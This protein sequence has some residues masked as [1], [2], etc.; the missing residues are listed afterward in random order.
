MTTGLI[1]STQVQDIEVRLIKPDPTQPRQVFDEG[2]LQNLAESLKAHGLKYPLRVRPSDEVG[3]EQTFFVVGG[4]RR[5]RAAC[6]AEIESLTCI[7]ND[8]PF[9]PDELL[10]EQLIDDLHSVGLS[11]LE[12]ARSYKRLMDLKRCS[13]NDL[14]QQLRVKRTSVTRPLSLLAL[15]EPL[16]KKLEAGQ[17]STQA[18]YLLTEL[19]DAELQTRVAESIEQ[20]EPTLR[21]IRAMVRRAKREADPQRRP[22]DGQ[23]HRTLKHYSVRRGV[24]VTLNS[25]KRLDA[26][27]VIAVHAHVLGESVRDYFSVTGQGTSAD[28]KVGI[29]EVLDLM[30]GLQRASGNLQAA[31]DDLLRN[32]GLL[33]VTQLIPLFRHPEQLIQSDVI[34]LVNGLNVTTKR[35]IAPLLERPA[36]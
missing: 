29:A 16:I 15:P 9:A 1:D 4:E 31:A 20:D 36:R 5:W 17:L 30:N 27:G 14:A 7:V 26:E 22:R 32:V 6:L 33:I 25:N 2:E 10:T 24:H 12:R 11:A 18:A 34:A 23:K 28:A 35:A 13:A 3:D 19:G 8:G 21:A